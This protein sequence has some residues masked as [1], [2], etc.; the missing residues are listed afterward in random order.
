MSRKIIAVYGTR[1]V[2]TEG[3]SEEIAKVLRGEGL[4]VRVVNAGKEKVKDISGYALVIVG[5][6]IQMAKWTGAAERFLKKFQ[7]ALSSKKVAIFVS[8]G[9]QALIEYEKNNEEIEKA[10]KQYLEDKAAKYDLHPISMVI[11]GGVWDFN[12]MFFLFRK[13]LASSKPKIE[14]AGFTEVKPG[15]YDTRD[16]DSI[17]TW[18]KEIATKV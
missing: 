4:D 18:A 8:S 13:T 10:R 17:R 11:F 12:K 3:T 1:Y 14:E 15:L 6:G 5:S 16:W 7:K 9:A 2:A